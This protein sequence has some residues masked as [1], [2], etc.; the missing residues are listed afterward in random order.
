MLEHPKNCRM[1][2]FLHTLYGEASNLAN[3]SNAN[4][5]GNQG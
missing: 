5:I 4:K 2:G 3:N 1:K